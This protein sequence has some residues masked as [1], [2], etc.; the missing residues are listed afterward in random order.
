MQAPDEPTYVTLEFE[1]GVPVTLN[2]EK[3]SQKEI[4]LKL[5]ELG[6]ANGIGLLGIVEHRLV[7]M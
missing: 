4:V 7:G 5:N 2:G 1:K 6:G 3:M